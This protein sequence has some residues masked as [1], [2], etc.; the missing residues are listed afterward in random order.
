MNSMPDRIFVDTNILVY[1][2]DVSAGIKHA[3]AKNLIQDLWENKT[4]CLSIQVM[5]EFYVNVTQ[6]VPNPMDY[7]NAIGIIRDLKYWKVHEPKIEDVLNAVDIQQRYQISFWDAMIL[8]SA[9]Q[10]ECSLLW[11]EDLNPDQ[12]YESVKLINP[13]Q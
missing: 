5:Q 3:T 12:V 7:V 2:H 1:A 11:S 8:Q 10:L 13:F 6:K 9:L 4:G